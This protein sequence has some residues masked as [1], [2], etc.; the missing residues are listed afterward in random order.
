M[1]ALGQLK[2]RPENEKTPAPFGTGV[3]QAAGDH[4]GR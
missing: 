3:S 2:R 1:E 4:L